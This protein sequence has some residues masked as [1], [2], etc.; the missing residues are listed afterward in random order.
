MTESWVVCIYVSVGVCLC[1]A[2]AGSPLFSLRVQSDEGVLRSRTSSS[3]TAPPVESIAAFWES[4]AR[5][6]ALEDKMSPKLER[7]SCLPGVVEDDTPGFWVL[8]IARTRDQRDDAKLVAP[9]RLFSA[10]CFGSDGAVPF[11]VEEEEASAAEAASR[12][13]RARTDLGERNAVGME[14]S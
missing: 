2:G 13:R 3:L 11:A 8:T 1:E 10:G 5:E 14:E 6:F 12:A 9:S 4:L 7:F